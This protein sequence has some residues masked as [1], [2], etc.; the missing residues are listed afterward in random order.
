[1]DITAFKERLEAEMPMVKNIGME[2][3][4]TPDS[5]TCSAVLH[6]GKC[7]CQPWGILSGG[8]I[9]AVAETLAG[10]ASCTLRPDAICV[11]MNITASH[12]HP[13]ANGED[14]TLTAYP[15]H[16]GRTTHLWRVDA[17]SSQGDLIST[18]NVTNYIRNK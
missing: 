15:I 8:A 2:L 5:D 18:V 17:R 14:V 4:S 9:L 11:G 10:V 1:M 6:V 16:L 3:V 7:N 12:V 13:A